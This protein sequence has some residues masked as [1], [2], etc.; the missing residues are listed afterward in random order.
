MYSRFLFVGLGGSGGKTLRFLKRDLHRW[1]RQHR[2]DGPLPTGWQFVNLDTPTVADGNEINDRVE[3]LPPDEYVGLIDKVI[4]FAGVQNALDLQ[5]GLHEAMATWRVDPVGVGVPLHIGAGQE[6]AIGQTVAVAY[7][8]SIQAKLKAR[9]ARLFGADV[10]PQLGK[11]YHQVTGKQPFE[12]ANVYIVVVSSLAGGS[13]AGLLNLVCDILSA[14]GTAGDDIFAVLYTPDVFGSLGGATT[15]GVQPNALAATAELINGM[16]RR[17]SPE[18]SPNPVLA[19]AGAGKLIAGSGPSFPFLVGITNAA[20]INFGT[21][22]TAFEMTGRSLVSWVTASAARSSFVSYTVANWQVQAKGNVLGPVLVD[23]GGVDAGFPQFSALGFA[24]VSVGADH[25]ENYVTQRLAR[26]ANGQL[27]DYHTSSEEA[28]R[29]AKDLDETDPDVLSRAIA[30]EHRDS[31]LRRAGLSEYGP[32]ENQIIDAM[33]PDSA[34]ED[35]LLDRAMELTG[36]GVGD[37]RPVGEW[38]A[39]IRDA[40]SEAQKEYSREYGTAVAV[41][42]E[43]WAEAI[44]GQLIDAVEDQVATRGLHV[45]KSLCELAAVHLKED[46]VPDLRHDAAKFREWHGGWEHEYRDRLED[47]SGNIDA[48]DQ[49]LEDAIRDAVHLAKFVG[50]ELLSDR[51]ADLCPEVAER[52]LAPL[53]AAL[54][55]SH[56]TAMA[57]KQK[58]VSWPA[59]GDGPPPKSLEPPAGEFTLIAAE[60]YPQHFASLMAETFPDLPVQQ[61]RGRV[62]DAGIDGRFVASEPGVSDSKYNSLRCL[63]VQHDWWPQTKWMDPMRT[64]SRLQVKAQTGIGDLRRRSAR[65]LHRGGTP[66]AKFLDLTLRSYLGSEALFAD[67]LSHQDAEANTARFLTQLSGAIKASA[68]LIDIDPALLGMVHQGRGGASHRRF[69]SEMPLQG[70]AAEAE[71]RQVLVGQG[72]DEQD[73]ADILG[74][75]GSLTYID[76]TSTLNAPH[77]LLVMKSLLEPIANAWAKASG[78]AQAR[79]S[80]WRHRRGQPLDK[81]V[82]VPQSMLLCMIRGWFTGVLLGHIDIGDGS[83]AVR[84]RAKKPDPVEFPFP[85]LTDGSD[86]FARLGQVLEALALANMRIG[87]TGSLDPLEPYKALRDLGKSAPDLS[88]YPQLTLALDAWIETGDRGNSIVGAHSYLTEIERSLDSGADESCAY[89]RA[90]GLSDVFKRNLDIYQQRFDAEI[91]SWGQDFSKITKAPLWI[92]LM[93]PMSRALGQLSI[94]CS[95]AAQRVESD[96]DEGF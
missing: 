95:A 37:K 4:G 12:A 75:D 13:G 45:A 44:Q 46:V 76:I 62:R 35:N 30:Q 10:Q 65:W 14:D 79:F 48:D 29:I 9:I 74:N 92:G 5:P 56:A 71:V 7:A 94:A 68:P 61:Q 36:V 90:V 66:F 60:S 21:H 38:I 63:S 34:L 86:K 43:R 49:A 23:E 16:W 84:I 19:T 52:L 80:F 26:D 59:W 53:A 15:G 83:R 72:V 47:L 42:A 25:F 88:A 11:L 64:A 20:G 51:A 8:S 18:Q 3:Q 50:D 24:R 73:L 33:R 57:D 96:A 58:V 93:R 32:D 22:D 89:Q 54:S 40:V 1:L 69:F 78:L 70:H 55:D 39:D 85:F 17:N 2:I 41:A 67:G 28:R 87:V 27:A 77:S 82:P 31:F 81:F 6:R 91:A